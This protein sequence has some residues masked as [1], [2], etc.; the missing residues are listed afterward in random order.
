[1]AKTATKLKSKAQLYVPQ[2][3]DD[4]ASDIRK[5]GDLMR[6]KTRMQADMNDKIAAITEAYQP[7]FDSISERLDVLQDGVQAYCE[8]HRDELTNGGKVK[9]ANLITG[10]VMWRQK[11]PSVRIS[12]ADVVIDT[13]KRL[14]L[15]KFV[16]S[17]E[18]V[19][20]D[21]IL[22]EP[23]EVRGVAGITVVTGEEQFE[24]NPF[25]QEA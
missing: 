17:K 20:K 15:G 6:E 16:R 3:K 13:L 23:D 18:E 24:I 21:A 10:E 8:A 9:S 1:M 5:V 2:T 11:P 25:E 22:N 4:A 19:N 7:K 12:K 14:G